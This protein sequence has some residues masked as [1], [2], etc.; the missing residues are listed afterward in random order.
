VNEAAFVEVHDEEILADFCFAIKKGLA[1]L[2][3]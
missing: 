2:F 3:S 1:P